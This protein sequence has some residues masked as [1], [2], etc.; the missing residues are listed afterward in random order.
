MPITMVSY[1]SAAAC[2]VLSGR[3]FR[4]IAAKGIYEHAGSLQITIMAMH[5]CCCVSLRCL[6]GDAIVLM[7]DRG[8]LGFSVNYLAA[9]VLLSWL[10]T[11]ALLLK[12]TQSRATRTQ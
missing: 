11:I 5:A 12:K 7:D 1:A 9:A 3:A 6:F 8:G 4:H 10:L 2:L